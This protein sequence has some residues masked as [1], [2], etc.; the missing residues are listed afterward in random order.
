MSVET[1]VITA[2]ELLAMP[3]DGAH[4]YELVQGE[5]I[6]MAPAGSRHGVVS[7]RLL[8]SISAHVDANQLGQ[9]YPSDTGFVLSRN[10]DTVRAP[11]VAF[12]SAGR[13]LDTDKF[14]PGAPDLAIEVVSPNDT[15][16][17]INTKVA[18]Y[19]RAGTRVVIVVEPGLRTATIRTSS[20]TTEVGIEGTLTAGDVLPGWS[21]RMRDLFR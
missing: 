3:D 19:L 9:V 13:M 15:Y 16:R 11:D 20:E 21:L 8:I 6:S 1:K 14:F 12:V 2:D 18:E 4:R 10:P 5:L 17:E 7:Q